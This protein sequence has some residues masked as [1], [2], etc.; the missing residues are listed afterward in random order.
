MIEFDV[1]DTQFD[2]T[3]NGTPVFHWLF[4]VKAFDPDG[5]IKQAKTKGVSAPIVQPVLITN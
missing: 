5:A 4:R 2:V 3:M 1:F